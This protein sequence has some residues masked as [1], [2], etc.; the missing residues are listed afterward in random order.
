[1]NE[2]PDPNA[3]ENSIMGQIFLDSIGLPWKC[4][5]C[6]NSFP[7]LRAFSIEQIFDSLYI[8][9]IPQ[10][11]VDMANLQLLC[12]SCWPHMLMW[13]A[14]MGFDIHT[15]AHAAECNRR[16]FTKT[17]GRYAQVLA[18]RSLINDPKSLF[19][20][21][22]AIDG[23]PRVNAM[24]TLMA[25]RTG[26][27][28]NSPGIRHLYYESIADPDEV[29]RQV[30]EVDRL[31]WLGV[32]LYALDRHLLIFWAFKSAHNADS[33]RIIYSGSNE[34]SIGPH[35]VFIDGFDQSTESFRFLNSW[36]AGWGDHGYGYVSM[37]YLRRFHYETFVERMVRWGPSPY[38]A[39]LMSK[40]SISD[41]ET[42][43]LW[44]IQNP[45]QTFCVREKGHNFRCTRYETLSPTT[46]DKITC[47]MITNGFGLRIGWCFSRY[48]AHNRVT[49]IT[50]LFVWPT[51]RRVG[52]G[53]WLEAEAVE[54]ARYEGSLEIQLIMNEADAII[55][56]PR[57]AARNFAAACG[58]SF[59]WRER[60]GPRGPAVGA[61]SLA[62]DERQ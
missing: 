10:P 11:G 42:R 55:G 28:I 18:L 23:Q 50:E 43:R 51:F 44:S 41:N 5:D 38:K 57:A 34:I 48:L 45:H 24:Y 17:N 14:R 8:A 13:N 61:K 29:R 40:T 33:G 32:P 21:G 36:G 19:R 56:P 6:G 3:I 12:S 46:N 59:R 25:C 30:V 37:D 31:R 62:E 20:L 2:Q 15:H 7:I 49:Q 58:Y 16:C 52:I 4:M 54:D 27:F 1:M 53:R 26:F 9:E 47:F 39:S 22:K 35:C 60:V